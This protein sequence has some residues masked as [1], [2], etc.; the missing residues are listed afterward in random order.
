MADLDGHTGI[1]SLTSQLPSG[2]F[3]EP[4]PHG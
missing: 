2:A 4:P 3:D 1:D